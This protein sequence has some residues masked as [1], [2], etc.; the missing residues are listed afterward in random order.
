[1]PWLR[2]LLI[3]L[4]ALVATAS[5]ALAGVGEGGSTPVAKAGTPAASTKA[6]SRSALRRQL[7]D[8]MGD[9]GG[10]SGAF[11]FD[12]DAKGDGT[13]YGND[14]DERRVPASNE[15][16]FTTAAFLTALGPDAH[17]QTRAYADGKLTGGDDSTLDGDLVM[18]GDGD[19]AFGTAAFARAHDQPVTRVATLARKVAGAGVERITGSV[20]ADDTIFDRE[21]RAGPDL[22][23]L[24]GLS[25]NDGFDDDGGY[26]HE[27]ELLAAR[28]MKH[29]LRKQGVEVAGRVAHANLPDSVLERKPLASAASPRVAALIEETNVP[30]NNFFAEMLLKR[31]AAADGSRGTR[32]AGAADV[33]RFAHAVGTDVQAVDGSGLSRRNAVSPHEVVKLLVAMARDR[34]NGEAFRNSLPIAG[35]EGTVADRMRGTAAE[36]NCA[37]KTGTLDGVSALSGYCDARGHTIAFSVLNNSVDINAAHVAQDRIAA[38]IA[39]YRH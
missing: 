6:L 4:I 23:P 5:P 38:A 14:G 34:D 25:F 12:V 35:R 21:R 11:V 18:V 39:R 24:S 22:S 8:A 33:E 26:A 31:L 1:M 37:T 10:A 20:L 15:K 32:I 36:G 27:P 2:A 7:A 16:L 28:A 9:V 30:S 29:A 3:S 17:L 19:P 13:L